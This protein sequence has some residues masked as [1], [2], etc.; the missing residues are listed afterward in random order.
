M[1]T[2]KEAISIIEELY[3]A[4][5]DYPEAAKIGSQLLDQAKRE[6]KDWRNES[7]EVLFRYADLCIEMDERQARNARSRTFLVTVN[8]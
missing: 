3:P 5:C 4:D 8:K 2:K 1:K 6:T 7:E